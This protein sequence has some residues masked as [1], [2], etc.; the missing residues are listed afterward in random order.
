[1][2]DFV[3]SFYNISYAELLEEKSRQISKVR[4]IL[5]YILFTYRGWKDNEIG[6]RYNRNRVCIFKYI[7]E[8]ETLIEKGDELALDL[9]MIE[10]KLRNIA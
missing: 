10:E 1:L 4:K 5:S 3:C 7:R 8:A 9:K 2:E 6:R